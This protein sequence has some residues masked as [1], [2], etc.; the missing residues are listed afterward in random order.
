MLQAAADIGVGGQAFLL[1]ELRDAVNA[2]R[3]RRRTGSAEWRTAVS[4][5]H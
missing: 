3:P 1:D 2:I 5:A 4:M